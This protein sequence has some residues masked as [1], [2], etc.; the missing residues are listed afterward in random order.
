M[1]VLRT[2]TNSSHIFL[3]HIQ[4][5]KNPKH[6]VIGQVAIINSNSGLGTSLK[7]HIK[8]VK[9]IKEDI[10]WNEHRVLYAGDESLDSTHEI[11]IA[12]HVN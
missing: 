11:S 5:G 2:L 6:T 4:K 1:R 3:R 8:G 7:Y 9:D 12:L 10:C